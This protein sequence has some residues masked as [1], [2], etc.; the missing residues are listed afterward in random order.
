MPLIRVGMVPTI[1]DPAASHLYRSA[2][3]I[4]REPHELAQFAR[5][6]AGHLGEPARAMRIVEVGAVV[7]WGNDDAALA[8][9]LL[10]NPA[11]VVLLV[12]PRK[13]AKDSAVAASMARLT[14]NG[15]DVHVAPF[16]KRS[17]AK[18]LD[19][20]PDRLVAEVDDLNRPP[21]QQHAPARPVSAD[22]APEAPAP[23]PTMPR[24]PAPPVT[25]YEA[26]VMPRAAA[27]PA[28]PRPAPSVPREAPVE[29]A[30]VAPP[31]RPVEAPPAPDAE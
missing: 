6:Q 24:A 26:P 22:K 14:A 20:G 5:A 28:E 3:I 21:Q 18:A 15:C 1:D 9:L 30:P 27:A 17:K 25:P 7:V 8:K 23:A 11:A 19:L 29:A 16:G 10:R 12:T 2:L 13:P 4:A 31:A